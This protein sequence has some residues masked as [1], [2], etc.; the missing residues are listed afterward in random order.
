MWLLVV[1]AVLTAAPAGMVTAQWNLTLWNCEAKQALSPISCFGR[2]VFNPRNATDNQPTKQ[3]LL[4]LLP[5]SKMAP[6]FREMP[7]LS[8]RTQNIENSGN[9]GH[10]L[11]NIHGTR[12]THFPGR[13]IKLPNNL[14]A[15]TTRT[16][17]FE[18][19]PSLGWFL[20]VRSLDSGCNSWQEHSH[21]RKWG[22]YI[23]NYGSQ[24]L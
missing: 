4:H 1:P 20:V 2:G 11:V 19:K 7:Y 22:L 8:E 5:A 23:C 6:I 17:P 10:T 21:L 12:Q 14:S 15:C 3:L 16:T 9:P 18:D 13:I 24:A